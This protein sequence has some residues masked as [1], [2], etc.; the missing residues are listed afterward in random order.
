MRADGSPWGGGIGCTRDKKMSSTP[1]LIYLHTISNERSLIHTLPI[2][3]PTLTLLSPP[4]ALSL[5]SFCALCV[6][7]N[8]EWG[9]YRQSDGSPGAA[10]PAPIVTQPSR[11]ERAVSSGV[12]DHKNAC[13]CPS[14]HQLSSLLHCV[15]VSPPRPRI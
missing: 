12:T 1:R 2:L 14:S 6:G 9:G 11:G 4:A 7:T 5:L 8:P 3:F 13:F 10:R 15:P